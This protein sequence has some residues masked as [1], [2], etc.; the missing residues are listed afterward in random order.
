MFNSHFWLSKHHNVTS[1][2][3]VNSSFQYVQFSLLIEQA[4]P[5]PLCILPFKSHLINWAPYYHSSCAFTSGE[6]R[7]GCLCLTRDKKSFYSVMCKYLQQPLQY[8]WHCVYNWMCLL[9]FVLSS[10]IISFAFTMSSINSN[11]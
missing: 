11:N 7:R 4:Q 6:D 3:L 5:I 8:D 9:I 2:S 1:H 10:L